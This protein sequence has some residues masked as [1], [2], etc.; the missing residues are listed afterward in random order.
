MR[1]A[2]TNEDGSHL[3]H[4]T[5]QSNTWGTLHVRRFGLTPSCWF[6]ALCEV[7]EQRIDGMIVYMCMSGSCYAVS[8][9]RASPKISPPTPV[10]RTACRAP[11][12]ARMG[13][14]AGPLLAGPQLGRCVGRLRVGVCCMSVASTSIRLRRQRPPKREP[15]RCITRCG[16]DAREYTEVRLAYQS[17]ASDLSFVLRSIFGRHA[18][19]PEWAPATLKHPP[20]CAHPNRS[21]GVGGVCIAEDGGVTHAARM[22]KTESVPRSA[23]HLGPR[24]MSCIAERCA[25]QVD[26]SMRCDLLCADMSR[27]YAARFGA[28]PMYQ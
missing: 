8:A 27:A 18:N 26:V 28:D 21:S 19:R 5:A 12:V 13:S 15:R 9:Q 6:L 11:H 25:R 22:R 3:D 1:R 4:T 17:R 2:K 24:K 10:I 16:T 23:N 20:D 14:S 7:C